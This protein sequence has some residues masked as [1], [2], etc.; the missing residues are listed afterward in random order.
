MA[1]LQAVSDWKPLG[2]SPFG[3]KW[4]ASRELSRRFSCLQRSVLIFDRP[5]PHDS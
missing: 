5:K 3:G 2:R 1:V 4:A